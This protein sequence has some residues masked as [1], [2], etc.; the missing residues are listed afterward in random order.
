MERYKKCT[1]RVNKDF[2][3]RRVQYLFG[4]IGNYCHYADISRVRFWE[5]VNTPHLSK[6]AECLQKLANYLQVSIDEILM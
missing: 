6:E 5:I 1:I 3:K 4:S 2:V